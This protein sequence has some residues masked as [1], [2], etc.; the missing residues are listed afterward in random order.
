RPRAPE[1]P[2][3]HPLRLVYALLVAADVEGVLHVEQLVHF[4]GATGGWAGGRRRHVAYLSPAPLPERHVGRK[5]DPDTGH[6]GKCSLLLPSGGKVS[7]WEA[8]Q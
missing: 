7:Q 6:A 3:L 5:Q 8:L 2:H 1:P 4:P